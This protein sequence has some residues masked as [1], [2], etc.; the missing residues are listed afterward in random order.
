MLAAALGGLADAHAAAISCAQLAVIPILVGCQ[1][2]TKI[3]VALPSLRFSS[4]V[5]PARWM[6][7]TGGTA[8]FRN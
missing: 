4:Q 1:L 5:G 2:I 7:M 3:V 6:A 8:I